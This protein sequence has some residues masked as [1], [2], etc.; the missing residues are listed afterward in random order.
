MTALTGRGKGSTCGCF[1]EDITDAVLA[2]N[3]F[4][5]LGTPQSMISHHVLLCSTGWAN[6][7]NTVQGDAKAVFEGGGELWSPR[8]RPSAGQGV[9]DSQSPEISKWTDCP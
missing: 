6:T 3:P 5:L 9:P 4:A 8:G 7:V 2:G 1:K